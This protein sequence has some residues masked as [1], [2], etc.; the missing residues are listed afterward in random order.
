M[1][2]DLQQREYYRIFAG[3]NQEDGYDNISLG[4]EAKT[5]EVFFKRDQS[6]FF[7]FP[8][9]TNV[10]PLS[11]STLGSSGAGAGPIPA[12]ADRIFKKLGNYSNTTPWGPTTSTDKINGTWL[13]S[14]YY[15][16]TTS[17][18]P[19]WVDRYYQPGQVSY[20]DALELPVNIVKYIENN[21][22][23]FD[24]PSSFVF[25]PGGYYEFFHRGEKTVTEIVET[26]SGID[27]NSLKLNIENWQTTEQLD[28]S[29]FNNNIIIENF[30]N[31]WITQSTDPG[32]IDR[33]SLSF[34]NQDFINC[35]V[36]YN[37]QYSLTNE[38]T[39]SFWI[40]ND[41]WSTA[42]STQLIG[43]LQ[44]SGYSVF[45]N[46]LN[47]NP[48]F[49]V[50]ETFYG[51]LFYFNIDGNVYLDK[52]IQNRLT[53]PTSPTL[54]GHNLN[55]ETIIYDE[56]TKRLLKYNHL[57]DILAQSQNTNGTTLTLSG[58]GKLLLLDGD[59]N[60]TV[61]TTSATYTFN[62]DLVLTNINTLTRYNN[63]ERAAYNM[64]GTLIREP[65]C[66]DII[67]DN[68]NNQWTIKNNSKLY[69]NNTIVTDLN[70]INCTNLAIDPE[71]NLWVLAQPNVV[72]KINPNTQK[73]VQIFE[74][75]ILNALP[76]NKNLSFIKS[77]NR[78]NNNFT[79]YAYLYVSGEQTVYQISLDGKII[80]NTFLPQ[81]LNIA[82]PGIKLQ[83]K[84]LLSFS[85]IGDFT[86]YEQRRIFYKL[87][88]N[89]NTQL[90]F[91]VGL[92]P[93]YTYLPFSTH[94][95]SIPINYLLNKSWH[96]ITVTIKNNFIS[97]YVDNYL[98]DTLKV[99][100]NTDLSYL[101]KN[102]LYIGCP[103]GKNTNLN[104]EIR[105]NSIIWNGEIDS[106]KIY[107]YPIKSEFIRFLAEEKTIGS[108][109]VW[110]INTTPLQYID[111]IER[112]FKH[113]LPGF[114]SNFFNIKIAGGQITDTATRQIVENN[115]KTAITRLK[116][117][118]TEI[119]KVEW[120]D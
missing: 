55:S 53:D 5:V 1:N 26:F 86:G 94:T 62:Q 103:N 115:I 2:N 60:T 4:Y 71:N 109:I 17:D 28:S 44:R 19:I 24:V 36:Q 120:V 23:Y 45:Y 54:I 52:N 92:K 77:Y 69:F 90:Q 21:Q 101:F 37:D 39:L 49:T 11:S 47:Y 20:E 104:Y 32:Y 67:F 68:N 72:Y 99:P 97:L 81:K 82:D 87:K 59:N 79:W 107:D 105:S 98:R 13:C 18:T 114:K 78:E 88:Y 95:L 106:I 119:L 91:K 65:Q 113:Q 83:N 50:P 89:N 56:I 12:M 112:F 96:L 9:F 42:T 111:T 63:S 6:T 116:P 35:F 10:L 7:H 34:N 80:K 31:N 84:N 74:A 58:V 64:L 102:D 66:I 41:N 33:S 100:D 75:G 46:N 108:D 61:I 85:S 51:H 38:F 25:E 3:T 14:W 43:N 76:G 93:P 15:A 70:T 57:G 29:N 48:Y 22:Q 110:E 118:Y 16:Q 73:V 30:N 8:F 40:K 117:A 27:K